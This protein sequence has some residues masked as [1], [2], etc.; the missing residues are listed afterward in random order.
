MNNDLA[1]EDRPPDGTVGGDVVSGQTN[2]QVETSH[3]EIAWR[4]IVFLFLGV[5]F[6]VFCGILLFLLGRK[7][8]RPQVATTTSVLGVEKRTVSETNEQQE[9]EAE[10]IADAQLSH[11]DTNA[12]GKDIWAFSIMALSAMV[13]LPLSIVTH[14]I[15]E[16]VNI[17][18]DNDPDFLSIG[19]WSV[20]LSY[21]GTTRSGGE[22]RCYSNVVRDVEGRDE[23][24][25]FEVD[26]ALQVARVAGLIATILGG[27]F[28]LAMI[29][30]A[31]FSILRKP[32]F[33]IWLS[34]L[35]LLVAFCQVLTLTLATSQ[36]CD[37]Y[38]CYFD[39]GAVS[40]CTACGYWL[41]CALAVCVVS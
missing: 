6:L 17:D 33:R 38:A 8:R 26:A 36:P 1:P 40:A 35:L 12:D 23:F 34:V 2:T 16:Y 7:R 22:G 14:T 4:M 3:S 21:D 18:N 10:P 25:D 41:V 11:Q 32:L 13:A 20:A 5:L 37:T 31:V 19:L 30:S 39:H 29:L 9:V 28:F 27:L 24:D 15:C